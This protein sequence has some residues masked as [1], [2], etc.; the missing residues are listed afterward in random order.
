MG[1]KQRPQHAQRR[2]R[3]GHDRSG[4]S[5]PGD[6]VAVVAHE[7]KLDPGVG[8]EL[9][10][11]LTDAGFDVSWIAIRKGSA[12]TGAVCD[13]LERGA[14]RIVVCGGDGTVRAA[15]Q[16]L[17]GTQTPL[18]VLPAGT[19]NLFAGALH[20]P[21]GPAEIAAAMR[22]G[23]TRRLDTGRCNGRSFAVM[24]GTGLDAAM[25]DTADDDKAR[26]GTLAYVRA[27]VREARRRT[28]FD[29]RVSVDGE[30][31]FEGEATCVLVANI[32]TLKGGI[33]AFPA[34][35]PEDG[36]LDVAVV[37]ATGLRQWG[38]M[39]WRTVRGAPGSS[40]HVHLT[41]GSRIMVRLAQRHRFELDGGTKGRA[42]TL[43]FKVVSASLSV[44]VAPDRQPSDAVTPD[45]DGVM[46][47]VETAEAVP[48]TTS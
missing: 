9:R 13:A 46:R 25:I 16:A 6:R 36:R 45:A 17:V 8:A 12:A 47:A 19:A 18:A 35:S 24:A 11:A 15:V 41:A 48:L 21:T 34:A 30:L 20:L 44:V 38:S 22:A 3:S 28:P 23:T 42:R 39:M 31:V 33:D 26:L 43:R 10:R 37:T 2:Q 27:G 32:G 29:A 40:D 14:D 5:V 7:R 1:K 4:A